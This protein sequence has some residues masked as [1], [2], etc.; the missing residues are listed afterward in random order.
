[1]RDSWLTPCPRCRAERRFTPTGKPPVI[2]IVNT[3]ANGCSRIRYLGCRLCGFRPRGNKR[4]VAL[5]FAP[6]RR[7]RLAATSLSPHSDASG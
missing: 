6:S 2:Q 5:E 1:M 7:E 4:I 3:E